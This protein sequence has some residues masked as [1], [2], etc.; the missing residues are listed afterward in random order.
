MCALYVLYV[1]ICNMY[2][3]IYIYMC[4]YTHQSTYTSDTK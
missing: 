2:V 1:T 4:T 3:Y